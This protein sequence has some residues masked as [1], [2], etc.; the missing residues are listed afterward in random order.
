MAAIA[1]AQGGRDIAI[2]TSTIQAG[3]FLH[4]RRWVLVGASDDA[5]ARAD[6]PDLRADFEVDFGGPV[7]SLWVYSPLH[8]PFCGGRCC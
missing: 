8:E 5:G 7:E 6:R 1:L 4:A 3:L 2:S